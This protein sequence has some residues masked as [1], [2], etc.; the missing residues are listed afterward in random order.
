MRLY[1]WYFR[2]N[3]N[4]SVNIPGIHITSSKGTF[5][6]NVFVPPPALFSFSH[7][8]ALIYVAEYSSSARLS[9]RSLH[10]HI[11]TQRY[12]ELGSKLRFTL[13]SATSLAHSVVLPIY[14]NRRRMAGNCVIAERTKAPPVDEFPVN[15]GIC[16]SDPVARARACVLGFTAVVCP[17][18]LLLHSLAVLFHFHRFRLRS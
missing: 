8:Q 5:S 9:A 13:P 14:R 2:N 3:G 4:R 11:R 12:P 15:Y 10:V 1:R 18:I 16:R 17:A 6:K 7:I